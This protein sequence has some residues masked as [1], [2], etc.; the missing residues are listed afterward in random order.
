[1]TSTR[2]EAIFG[3]LAG[4]AGDDDEGDPGGEG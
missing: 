1:M 2:L 4:T 3:P